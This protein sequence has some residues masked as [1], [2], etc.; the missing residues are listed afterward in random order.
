MRTIIHPPWLVPKAKTL[1]TP[2]LSITCRAMMAE[3]Q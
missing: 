3:S 2:S 1:S